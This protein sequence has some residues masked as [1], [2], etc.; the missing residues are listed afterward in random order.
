MLRRFA[1]RMKA[2]PI[3]VDFTDMPGKGSSC[4]EGGRAPLR[5]R[6]LQDLDIHPTNLPMNHPPQHVLN[7]LRTERALHEA[8]EQCDQGP[9]VYTWSERQ[10][11]NIDHEALRRGPRYAPYQGGRWSTAGIEGVDLDEGFRPGDKN[12]ADPK[13]LGKCLLVFVVFFELWNMYANR[14]RG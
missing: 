3:V 14:E 1:F 13:V 6:D 7:E 4:T 9:P 10:L 5:A 2:S 8:Q 11:D 12:L